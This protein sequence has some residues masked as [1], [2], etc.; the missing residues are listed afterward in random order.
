MK[1]SKLQGV[2]DTLYI[3][4][5]ARIYVSKRFPDF[6]HD[7]KSL[8]LESAL[9]DD[10]IGRRTNEYAHL[11]SVCRYYN[12]DAMLRRFIGRFPICNVVNL[13]C[14]LETAWWR[15]QPPEGVTFYEM[16]LPEV[17]ET[18]RR[19]LGSSVG[20]RLVA[21][22]LFDLAWADAIDASLPTLLT[23]S[24]VF[25][26]FR[27]EQVLDFLR[28]ARERFPEGEIIFDATGSQGIAYANRFVRRT[29]NTS[30]EM[31]F[32]VDD[33]RR[34]TALSATALVEER[35]FF[36]DPL[37]ILGQRLR[38]YTRIAMRVARHGSF[39]SALYHLK[40]NP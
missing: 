26:Y 16:D 4:L 18:R 27:E 31:H 12:L 11:A 2:A 6:F 28:Q 5:T 23:V 9:P 36:R 40:L 7:S 24:G 22:D 29:G 15:L 34:L 21:G 14:G 35:D 19:L 8:E 17:I 32:A 3:P 20:D 37:R 10:S 13:G 1:D 30:A 38:P 33:I 25:Q 39:R